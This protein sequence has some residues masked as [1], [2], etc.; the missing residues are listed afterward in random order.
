MADHTKISECHGAAREALQ[1]PVYESD[2]EHNSLQIT[3][4][5]FERN[6][7]S[8]NSFVVHQAMVMHT[9]SWP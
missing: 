5:S 1:C 3:T 8:P 7:A 9:A 2:K 6:Q 4:R